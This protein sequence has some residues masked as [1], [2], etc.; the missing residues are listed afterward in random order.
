VF[1]KKVTDTQ[2]KM[3]RALQ[4]KV[5]LQW[6]EFVRN[7]KLLTTYLMEEKELLT[8]SNETIQQNT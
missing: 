1:K 7:N 4:L 8:E 3:D 6:K 5:F 2:E